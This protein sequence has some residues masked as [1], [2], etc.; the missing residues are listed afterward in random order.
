MTVTLQVAILF[1]FAVVAVITAFPDPT[2]V[3]FP[4]WETLTDE[5]LDDQETLLFVALAG[6]ITAVRF[7]LEL[8]SK[9]AEVL[10]S[11]TPVTET[12][13]A[14]TLT[15]QLA[16]RR[17]SMVLTLIVAVPGDLAITAPSETIATD[18]SLDHQVTPLLVAFAGRTV[19]VAKID[20]ILFAGEDFDQASPFYN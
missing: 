14:I 5:L 2:A 18:E 16:V 10:L 13:G 12:A 3:I 8:K 4:V 6:L 19:A 7:S 1:P 17:P 15:V 9:P 20:A 11:L